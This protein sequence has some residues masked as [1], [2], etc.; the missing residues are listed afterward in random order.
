MSHRWLA[1]V[2]VALVVDTCTCA[3]LLNPS[4]VRPR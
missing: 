4:A 2:R 3:S 1:L